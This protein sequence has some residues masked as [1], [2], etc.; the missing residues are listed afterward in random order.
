[1]KITHIFLVHILAAGIATIAS[2]ATAPY[3]YE[4]IDLSTL[5]GSGSSSAFDI[6]NMGQVIGQ[7]PGGAFVYDPGATTPVT[8]LSDATA[9]LKAIN[10]NGQAVGVGSAGAFVYS[11][12]TKSMVTLDSR[13]IVPNGI[14]DSGLVTGYGSFVVDSCGNHSTRGFIDDHGSITVLG[15]L[16]PASNTDPNFIS[17]AYAINNGGQ[18]VGEAS[19]GTYNIKDAF[20]TQGGQMI[21]LGTLGGATSTANAI[22]DSGQVVGL[23]ATLSLGNHPFVYRNGS[24][25]DLA[26]IIFNSCQATSANDINNF[27]QVVGAAMGL[28]G[29]STV[30]LYDGAMTDLNTVVN[31]SGYRIY[32]ASAVNDLGQIAAIG[33]S[34]V[35][36]T[37]T[38]ALILTPATRTWDGGSAVDGNWVS[39]ANWTPDTV[40]AKGSELI[41]T[42]ALR[43]TNVNN[44]SLTNVGLVT[45]NNGGFNISGNPLILNAG[46]ISTADTASNTWAIESTLYFDQSFTSMSGTLVISGRV[47]N[48]GYL[49]TLDGP[50]N[51]LISG[52]VAGTGG[53]T[54]SGSGTATLSSIHN[55]Y[56]GST[57]VMA[58]VLEI[59][60]GIMPGTTPLINVE[61]GMAVLD[62]K[63]VNNAGL[64]VETA[65]GATFAVTNG[66]HAIGCVSGAGATDISGQLTVESIT[67]SA[68]TLHPGAVLAIAALPGGPSS[69]PAAVTAVP[70]PA[71][72]MLF[73]AA[74]L[75]L[76]FYTRRGRA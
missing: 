47:N 76:L 25:A 30:Y 28:A 45:F 36:W 5:L 64:N 26:N 24:M 53:L 1:V 27:G 41:F 71:G 52:I 14:N 74:V 6:N 48:G 65:A 29:G 10:N 34:N 22:N 55:I 39:A 37:Y 15:T 75:S 32:T 73:V 35:N 49:L 72:A 2:G 61:A 17:K 69:Q 31:T 68:I 18:V 59:S 21:N 57:T 42:G 43:Q 11:C 38:R 4:V 9:T 62:T 23:A 60:G 44:T 12:L 33:V 56:R 63:N 19:C 7:A 16:S 54:K 40:P 8:Y 67:Q 50:G 66:T 46:I 20:L 51:H 58:G 13:I 70:E 3:S